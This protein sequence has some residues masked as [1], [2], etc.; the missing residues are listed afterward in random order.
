MNAALNTVIK[1]SAFYIV[2]IFISS[3][4]K[5]HSYMVHGQMVDSTVTPNAS[6]SNTSFVLT[7][8]YDG[9]S[10]SYPMQKTPYTFVTDNN[11]NFSVSF[12]VKNLEGF[13]ISY[14]AGT[15]IPVHVSGFAS[16]KY[17][18]DLGVVKTKKL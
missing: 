17:N 4:Q 9:P 10:L 16:N 13:I 8:M 2:I 1:L 5:T 15:V 18:Y 14:P 6:I 11:G 3:C 7:V 12:D